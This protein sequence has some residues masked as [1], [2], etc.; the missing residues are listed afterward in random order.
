LISLKKKNKN[1]INPNIFIAVYISLVFSI[2][3]ED[4]NIICGNVTQTWCTKF[5]I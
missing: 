3:A 5:T 2:L 4:I 1:L